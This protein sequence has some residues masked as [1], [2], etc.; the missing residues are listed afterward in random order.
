MNKLLFGLRDGLDQATFYRSLD[1]LEKL[2]KEE[3]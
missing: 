3:T 1:C 2:Y